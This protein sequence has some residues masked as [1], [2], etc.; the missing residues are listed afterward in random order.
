[1]QS[2]EIRSDWLGK[3]GVKIIIII[4]PFLKLLLYSDDIS[5]ISPYVRNNYCFGF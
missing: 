3:L 5:I 4:F 1:M 2:L